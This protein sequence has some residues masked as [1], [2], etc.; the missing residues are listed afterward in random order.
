MPIVAFLVVSFT[1]MV[2]VNWFFSPVEGDATAVAAATTQGLSA[3][4]FKVVP[5]KP[6]SQRLAQ[7]PGPQRIG[8][9]AGHYGFD[10][11]A[12]CADGLTEAKV[13][14][15]I[16]NL[17]V[18]GLQAQGI[19]SDLLEEFDPRL[20]NYYATAVI[21]IHA[22]SCDYINQLA[23]GFKLSG[24]TLTDSSDLSICMEQAYQETTQ[25]TYHA[26]TVTADMT[27]YHAF[28]EIAPGVPAV[29]IEVG[30]LNLDRELLAN[31]ETPAAGLVNGIRCY[32]DQ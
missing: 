1:G 16:A 15:S 26:N 30:F 21:S 14:M 3:P 19:R 32:L 25:L 31:A 6:V 4:I 9:I 12:V 7:S 5:A 8:I 27:N 18:A 10:S 23:T 24:S 29:I 28:R 2:A 20:E 13:N 22:D 11:G 17:V